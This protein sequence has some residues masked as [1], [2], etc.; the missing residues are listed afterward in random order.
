MVECTWVNILNMMVIGTYTNRYDVTLLINGLPVVQVELKR[1]GLDFNDAFNRSQRY[2]KHFYKIL[3]RFLQILVVTNGVDTKYFSH[4]DGYILF[5]YTFYWFDA[6]NNI[7]SKWKRSLITLITAT[8]QK[9]NLGEI[10]KGV[11]K[12]PSLPK[13]LKIATLLSAID[14]RI[15]KE[16]RKL[17]LLQVQ[18]KGMIQ[19]MLI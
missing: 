13:Q 18:K 14:K 7:I 19:Q 16:K 2:R 4:S 17:E 15:E 5:G 11:F 12:L 6:E 1:E 10:S 8:P 3:Y 9:I